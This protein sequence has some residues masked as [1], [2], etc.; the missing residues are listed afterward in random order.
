MLSGLK[1]LKVRK[2]RCFPA[3][4]KCSGSLFKCMGR[5][6]GL[7]TPR[8][9]LCLLHS[10]ARRRT[11]PLFLQACLPGYYRVDG[12]LFGGICQPCEC[13]GHSSECDIHGI[14]SVSFLLTLCV[15]NL[16][17]AVCGQWL[18]I[19]A[20]TWQSPIHLYSYILDLVLFLSSLCQR[21]CVLQQDDF[22]YSK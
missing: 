7:I 4:G 11:G 21:P 13:H 12:I 10:R 20:L 17:F 9:A 14:C 18:P 1:R 2:E 3:C 5:K 19:S 6:I 16:L 8:A 15:P 22:S